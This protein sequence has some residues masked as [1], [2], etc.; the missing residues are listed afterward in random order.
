MSS[1]FVFYL[2]VRV[3]VPCLLINLHTDTSFTCIVSS[4]DNNL[5]G[6][7]MLPWEGNKELQGYALYQPSC[8]VF[9][10]AFSAWHLQTELYL[11]VAGVQSSGSTGI[12]VSLRTRLHLTL[13]PPLGGRI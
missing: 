4:D 10:K 13:A 5:R 8:P 12:S 11:D 7:Y 6:C 2:W 9:P 3:P 1:L